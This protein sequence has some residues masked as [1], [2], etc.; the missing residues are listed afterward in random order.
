MIFKPTV[1][2]SLVVRLYIKQD[3]DYNF[4]NLRKENYGGNYLK[5][6]L[7]KIN[8]IWPTRGA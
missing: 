8:P 6:N 7:W 1:G 3:V 4:Q 5:L 2:F